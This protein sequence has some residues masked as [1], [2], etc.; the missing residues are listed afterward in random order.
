[1]RFQGPPSSGQ[2]LATVRLSAG[3]RLLPICLLIC[4]P[5]AAAGAVRNS[6]G[7]APPL[8]TAN[9]VHSLALDEAAKAIPVRLRGVVTALTTYQSSFFVEDASGGVFIRRDVEGLDVKPGQ[10]VEVLGVTATGQF[11]PVVALSSM[12]FLGPGVMPPAPE[13]PWEDLTGGKQ[14]SRWI[15]LRGVVH[16]AAIEPRWGR[17][18][19]ALRLE[20]KSGNLV[21]VYVK[22]HSAGEWE[23][24]PG[25]AV[26][27]HG[28]CGAM[29]NDREQ[30]LG[31][32][33]FASS[34]ANIA[35]ERPAPADPFALPT[36]PIGSLLQAGNTAGRIPQVKVRGVVTYS[37]PGRALFIQSED[38]GV[39][40]LTRQA[41]SFP[42]GTELEAVGFPASDGYSAKLNDS[43]LRAVG[44]AKPVAARPVPASGL[45]L[46]NKY[47][48]S[49]A[50][51]DSQL[52]QVN[53]RLVQQI[54]GAA[55]DRLILQDGEH[56]F[57][58]VLPGVSGREMMA[59]GTLLSLTGVCVARVDA[60]QE[61]LHEAQ[62]FELLLR[63][64]AD[65]LVL[66]RVSWWSAEH[67]GWF[68]A[69][70]LIVTLAVVL[71][72]TGI[73]RHR[74]LHALAMTDP[75]TGLYNSR[76]F[77]LLAEQNWQVALRRKATLALLY[78]DLDRFK[79][80]NDTFGHK[81]GDHALRTLADL[82]RNCFRSSDILARLGGDEFVVL[83]NG[84]LDA[85]D[86]I[87]NRLKEDLA[88]IN[89]T[90]PGNAQLGFSTGI[91]VCDE[92]MADHSIR[93]LLTRAD[94]RMYNEKRKRRAQAT[95]T[96]KA[97]RT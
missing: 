96:K 39:R 17:N 26:V 46:V 22:D 53:G 3:W 64:P 13:L 12:K 58:A 87:V 56:V 79:E 61:E 78:I 95:A 91:L 75:L 18:E 65:I 69:V 32:K 34:L 62:S 30:F 76:G 90:K 16:S 25:A 60:D 89:K 11:A 41:A 36:R 14:D 24:L 51:Y 40:I 85:V 5:S 27:V 2:N 77:F 23:K 73:R 92:S 50:P 49:I 45:M 52:V 54:S 19:L 35:L 81:E 86:A 71:I 83:C 20:I 55:E 68:V 38:S 66:K 82:L 1:M 59:P 37:Q 93:E 80:I 28:V 44:P 84:D 6:Q 21:V 72:V 88:E 29:V 47:G 67:A 31:I 8:T 74:M 10:R 15:T 43:V 7:Q 57:V 4:V 33:M 94:D 9:A 70:C 97:L 42:V 48:F 63:S